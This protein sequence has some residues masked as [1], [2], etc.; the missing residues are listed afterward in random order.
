[1]SFIEESVIDNKIRLVI[2][3]DNLS[4]R[5]VEYIGNWLDDKKYKFIGKEYHYKDGKRNDF[6]T[7][8]GEFVR[9]SYINITRRLLKDGFVVMFNPT[10]RKKEFEGYFVLGDWDKNK[11]SHLYQGNQTI[12]I[13]GDYS[14]WYEGDNIIYEGGYEM[15]LIPF[16]SKK[17]EGILYD[18]NVLIGTWD[19]TKNGY[20][21]DKFGMFEA[22]YYN[23]QE[24]VSKKEVEGMSI[25]KKME[26]IMKK[27]REKV[28]DEIKNKIV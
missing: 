4:S 17:G 18:K 26:Y 25:N 14:K 21:T 7:C 12:K 22:F 16:I 15:G 6:F 11:M 27:Y 10:T 13:K 28:I 23:D 24:L 5:K 19:V 20:F 1:M 3:P 8:N 2:H 9:S